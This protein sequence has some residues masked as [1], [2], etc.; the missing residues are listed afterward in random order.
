VWG[1]LPF[2][3]A[4]R[5]RVIAPD[6]RGVGTSRDGEPFTI[7]GAVT[8]LEAV[9]TAH[10]DGRVSLLGASLGGTIGLAFAA[11]HPQRVARLVVASCASRPSTYTRRL[12]ESF[13]GALDGPDPQPFG[14]LL[15]TLAFAPTFH[16]RFSGLVTDAIGMYGPDPTDLAGVLG[17]LDHLR[18]G[19][20]VTSRLEQIAC[21]TMVVA[22][23][24]DPIVPFEETEEIASRIDGS[25]LV[26]VD[27]ASHSV[28]LEGGRAVLDRVVDFLDPRTDP[29]T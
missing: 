25:T 5:F 8:D 27:D 21:P 6:N 18:S 4:R 20:D 24:R 12:F 26:A 3:L 1:D 7:D 2:R 11:A 19:W 29:N 10:G 15:M 13:R 14:E 23:R 28:L 17:Q 16:H 22:G 9:I